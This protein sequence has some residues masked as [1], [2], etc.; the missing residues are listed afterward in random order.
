[1]SFHYRSDTDTSAGIYTK[2]P[3]RHD[4]RSSS[5]DG[6]SDLVD[7]EDNVA[8]S[9]EDPLATQ[10]WKHY[11][12]TKDSLLPV[13]RMENLTWRMMALA[14][15]KRLD[16]EA[17]VNFSSSR[18]LTVDTA[19]MSNGEGSGKDQETQIGVDKIQ[20]IEA[21]DELK[22]LTIEGRDAGFAKKNDEENGRGRRAD[23]GWK[24]KMRV[25]G[26]HTAVGGEDAR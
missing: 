16:R 4:P 10:V 11:A 20:R 17:T 6:G 8:L 14:L 19:V 5:F 9:G 7:G 23:R 26:F 3:N 21:N 15:R 24:P 22:P 25:E 18:P 13:Q 2:R 1:M 12:Y